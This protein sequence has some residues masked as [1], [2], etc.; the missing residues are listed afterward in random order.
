M[1]AMWEGRF[2]K[3]ASEELTSFNASLPFDWRLYHHDIQGSKVHARMLANQQI[4]SKEDALKIQKGL[5][6]IEADIEAGLIGL[7]HGDYEDIHMAI[8]QILTERIG[9]AGKRLHTGRSRNDQVALD[10]R[11]Y[12]RDDLNKIHDLLLNLLDALT[13]KAA[14]SVDAIMP[15]YTHLQRAQPVTFGHVLMAYASMIMRDVQR[16]ENTLSLMNVSPLGSCALA[17][18]T[19]PLDRHFTAAELGFDGPCLNS[20]DGV[21]DRDY[22]VEGLA[23]LSLIMMHLSRLS[24]EVV[25]WCSWE[26]KFIELGDAYATG[27]SIMPQKKNPDICELVRGKTGRVYGG[28]MQMLTM[29]KGLSLAYNKDMQEDKESWFDAADTVIACLKILPAML[30]GMTLLRAN[31]AAAAE[32]GFINATDLADYLTK[33]GLPFRDAYKLTGQMVAAAQQ[34]NTTLNQMPLEQMQSF[35]AL[36]EADVFEAIDLHN[37]I[38]RRKSAGGPAPEQVLLQIDAVK[39]FMKTHNHTHE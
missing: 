33:K 22:L 35:S 4:I 14:E 26:F 17:G 37:C 6:G 23:D 25:A 28:L 13:E 20:L 21:S 1:K 32:K 19:Y 15:G 30:T 34:Q 27:S 3:P 12:V 10:M 24:E 9:D 31:M 36:I 5:E 11:M 39:Q 29:L 38:S 16:L 7:A 18:T 2:S 8:E